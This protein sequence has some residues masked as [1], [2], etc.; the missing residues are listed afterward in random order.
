MENSSGI[1]TDQAHSEKGTRFAFDTKRSRFTVQAFATGVLSAMGHNPKI[2]IRSINGE[3]EF[4]PQALE[5]SGLHLTIQSASLSV[6]N[7]ISDK[8]RREIERVMNSEVLEV[9]RYPEI[10]YDASA[11]SVSTLDSDLYS[12]DLN[13]DL[14]FHGVTRKQPV[15]VRIAM[16]GE[17]LRASGDFTMRQSDYGIKPVSVAGGALK[18]KDELRFSFDVI[19]NS[20]GPQ[21]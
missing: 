8:D 14:S 6:L 20:E 18:L 12:A 9:D 15:T 1:V 19:A 16:M 21:G 4:D 17:R 5:A 3:V 7:D 13:G 11:I 2:D 10:R